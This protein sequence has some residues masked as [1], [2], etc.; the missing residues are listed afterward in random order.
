[1]RGNAHLILGGHDFPIFIKRVGVKASWIKQY[2]FGG[3]RLNALGHFFKFFSRFITGLYDHFGDWA[4][5]MVADNHG[6][7]VGRHG[8][9]AAIH[10][11]DRG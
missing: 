3:A 10:Q 7:R 4:I 9:V 5:S 8:F 11:N 2:E 1:M 6:I